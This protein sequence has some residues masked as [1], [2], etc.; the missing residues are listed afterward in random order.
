MYRLPQLTLVLG[1][2]ASGKSAWAERLAEEVHPV[3]VYLATADAQDAEMQARVQVHRNRRGPGW[4]TIEAGHDLE[5]AL[6]GVVPGRV[7]LIDCAT[8]WLN[9]LF[10]RDVE[11]EPALKAF[12]DAIGACAAPVIVVS[13]ELGQ[14]LVPGDQLSRRFRQAHGEMNQA[15]AARAGLVVMIVAGLPMALKGHLPEDET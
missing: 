8:M 7:V 12:S 2:A 6:A 10:E 13:N 3:R 9:A 5:S 15:L 14:G 1:G 11:I 4:R